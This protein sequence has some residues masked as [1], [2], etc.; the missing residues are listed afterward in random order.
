M[1]GRPLCRLLEKDAKFDFDDAF[2]SASKEIKAILVIAF[3]ISTPNWRKNF[4]IVCDACHGS[5]VRA[6]Y[7]ENFHSH[8][9]C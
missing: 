8:L 6:K 7:G 2:K 4:E 1:I 9:L 5:S 3:V